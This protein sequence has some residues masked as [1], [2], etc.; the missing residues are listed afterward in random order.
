MTNAVRRGN[1]LREIGPEK[2]R[3][4]APLGLAIGLLMAPLLA[5]VLGRRVVVRG[6][7]MSP[8]LSSGEYVLFDR[9]TGRLL[10]PERGDIVLARN[11]RQDPPLVIKRVAAEPG[12]VV[13]LTV[14]GGCWVNGFY[15]GAGDQPIPA[16]AQS[17]VLDKGEF[18]LLGDAPDMSTDSRD[19]GPLPQKEIVGRARLV[20]WPPKAIR[21]LR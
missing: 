8:A 18:F 6:W 2:H 11:P 4:P 1:P 9:L 12:D 15:S 7:S 10:R 19:Y 5:F 21:L 3:R 16:D 17:L 13:H 20:Y 14:G